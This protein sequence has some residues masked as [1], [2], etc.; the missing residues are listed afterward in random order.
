MSPILI[1]IDAA[2]YL[3]FLKKFNWFQD[4]DKDLSMPKNEL[5]LFVL[6]NLLVSYVALKFIK[7][8]FEKVEKAN[9]W[10]RIKCFVMKYITQA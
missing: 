8:Y 4:Y 10:N 3:L 1:H 9:Y 7:F 6:N 2:R 5:I